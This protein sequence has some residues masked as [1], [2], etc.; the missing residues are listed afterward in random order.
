[1]T[2]EVVRELPEGEW[3][4]FVNA[5]PAGN[6]FQTPEMLQV[7]SQA[8]NHRPELWAAVQNGC[9]LALFLPVRI[10]LLGGPL[11]PLTTRSVV[12]GSVLCAS[13]P[14]GQGALDR[15]LRAY[16]QGPHP[17]SLFT[18]LRNLSDQGV[19]RPTLERHGFVH[20]K[21]LNYLIR[22]DRTEEEIFRSIGSRT[23]KNIRHGQNQGKIIVEEAND[24]IGLAACYDLLRQTYK[25]ARVPLADISLFES[26]F[27]TLYP[28]KMMKL[29]LARLEGVLAAVSVD[30]LFK[31][32]MYGWYG[33]VD[34][35]CSRHPVHELL[36][37]QILKWGSQNGYRWYDFGGAGKPGEKYGV[38][39]FKAKFGGELVDYGRDIYVHSR[40]R[41]WLSE[42]GYQIVRRWL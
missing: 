7:F 33:G 20:E 3:S 27:D 18:E 19:L 41:L 5:H 1:M 25:A 11:Q 30:L 23:R 28:K 24:R 13:T 17:N 14:E 29:T 21:H 22:L 15:L 38:R 6:I 37:W 35:S 40:R 12:Y 26:A 2:I 39:D 16:K 31:D 36:M 10:N 32:V 42:R 8:R 9:V 34:R 4:R